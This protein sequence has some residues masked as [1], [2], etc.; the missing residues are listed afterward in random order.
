MKKV[1]GERSLEK[2]WAIRTVEIKNGRRMEG[3]GKAWVDK[4]IRPVPSGAA[5]SSGIG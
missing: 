5:R 3:G 2:T 4:E 1:D